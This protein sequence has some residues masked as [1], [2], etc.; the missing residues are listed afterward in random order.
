MRSGHELTVF[1]VAGQTLFCP[2]EGRFSFER[3]DI[4]GLGLVQVFGGI[5]VTVGTYS[6]YRRMVTA[7]KSRCQVFMAFRTGFDLSAA[8]FCNC[9]YR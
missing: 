8:F 4:P 7:F 9:R 6:F 5:A 1:R 2:G 3:K